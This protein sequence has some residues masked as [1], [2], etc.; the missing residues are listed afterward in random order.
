MDRVSDRHEDAR[1]V[2]HH[3]VSRENVGNLDLLLA[4]SPCDSRADHDLEPLAEPQANELTQQLI[5]RPRLL[6]HLFIKILRHIVRLALVFRVELRFGWEIFGREGYGGRRTQ[7]FPFH[8]SHI[9]GP[10]E[11][12][13]PAAVE[14]GH[15]HIVRVRVRRVEQREP[16]R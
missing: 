6:Q 10:R 15:V 16:G 8:D 7:A 3:M 9:L 4:K 12:V 14:H 2:L 1:A 11:D 5:A 13:L